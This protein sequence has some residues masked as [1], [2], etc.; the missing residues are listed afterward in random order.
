[1]IMYFWTQGFVPRGQLSIEVSEAPQEVFYCG[2]VVKCQVLNVDA[3]ERKLI[4]S[5]KLSGKKA[6]T[7]TKEVQLPKRLRYRQGMFTVV[8]QQG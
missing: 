6:K 8:R 7:T 1:M 3:E 4:L 5:F 2:Q